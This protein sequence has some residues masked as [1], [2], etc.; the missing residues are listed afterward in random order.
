[1]N[2]SHRPE[3]HCPLIAYHAP[4]TIIPY[5]TTLP[6]VPATFV[7]REKSLVTPHTIA[8]KILPPSKGKPGNKL[9]RARNRASNRDVEFLNGFRRFAPDARHPAKYK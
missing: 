7:A 5:A 1:M 3:V 4:K 9:K 6:L 2:A 8:R